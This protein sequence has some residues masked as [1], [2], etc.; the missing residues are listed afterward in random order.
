MSA[1]RN[2]TGKTAAIIVAAGSGSRMGGNIP[3]QYQL[4]GGKAVLAHSCDAFAA[5]P[6]IDTLIVVIGAGQEVAT[7]A[8]LAHATF[9][10]TLVTGGATRQ[11]SVRAGLDFLSQ[12]GGVD[13]VLIH[14]AA[15]PLLTAD[16]INRLLAALGNAPGAVPVLPVVDTLARGSEN[17]LGDRVERD[18]L[19]HVQTPQ[20][21]AFSAIYS[22][23]V[24]WPNEREATDDA[25]MLRASGQQV[26]LVMGDRQ[27]DKITHVDDFARA[28][29]AL[30]GHTL[31]PRVGMGY[32][33]HRLTPGKE[34]W[35]CGVKIPHEF[36]LSGHSDADVALHALVD[37]ILG[38]LSEG[39]IGSHFPPADPQ[40][41]GA[42]SDR[43]LSFARDRVEARGGRIGHVDVTIICEA[44]K[45]APYRDAMRVRL[46]EL[47]QI[48]AERISVKATTTEGLGMTG[49]REGIAA[50]AV[51]TILLP[52]Q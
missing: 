15:R 21:F 1:T 12:S 8:A 26:A 39:D 34:L 38:A 42:S 19:Y 10:Y 20:A 24:D 11:L 40:W 28:E 35:L 33:V 18:N 2:S 32:D 23:H 22:A 5:H 52:D 37:A 36:G 7:Q 44:P 41:K 45:I 51:A 46:A 9:P 43:F 3:K 47:L 16:V 30:T 4:L 25:G 27:L 29:R 14:D 31:L 50:Q 17:M 49:R 6:A 13:H 48:E